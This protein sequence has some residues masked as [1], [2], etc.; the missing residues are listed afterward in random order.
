MLGNFQ[1]QVHYVIKQILA[2]NNYIDHLTIM[3][4]KMNKL[5]SLESV[6]QCLSD[7]LVSVLMLHL[8][9]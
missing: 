8:F 5:S 3:R 2:D 6:K 9:G 4:F 7:E 1:F